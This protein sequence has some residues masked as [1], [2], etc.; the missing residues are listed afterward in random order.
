MTTTSTSDNPES[1]AEA[2]KKRKA[3]LI[4]QRQ[5]ELQGTERHDDG[6]NEDRSRSLSIASASVASD[7]DGAS[8]QDDWDSLSKKQRKVQVRYDPA[9]PMDKEE[10]ANWRRQ[11]R[12]VRNRESAAASRQRIRSRIT[13]LEGEVEEWKDKYNS[14]M[15]RLKTMREAKSNGD[16]K[17]GSAENR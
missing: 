9:I 11:H 5:E 17:K 4:Q 16:R 13:E 15:E 6:G 12:K 8:Q 3:I 1:K 7:S 14:A 10:L 2:R